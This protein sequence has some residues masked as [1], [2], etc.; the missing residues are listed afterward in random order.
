[1]QL[2]TPQ[3][4]RFARRVTGGGATIACSLSVAWWLTVEM[5][6]A[7][8]VAVATT[9]S[10]GQECFVYFLSPA[11]NLPSNRT[12]Q[13]Q[14]KTRCKSSPCKQENAPKKPHSNWQCK[15]NALPR[16]KVVQ[17]QA[18]QTRQDGQEGGIQK[19]A[20]RRSGQPSVID[21]GHVP[22]WPVHTLPPAPTGQPP[23]S[24]PV[25]TPTLPHSHATQ[26][27]ARRKPGTGRPNHA[28]P[29]PEKTPPTA[30]L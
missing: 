14:A 5:A 24:L 3:P 21:I 28:A 19:G 25:H 13:H 16:S 30:P 27:P 1:M 4:A 15:N 17:M 12:N 18:R 20:R 2:A 29:N 6:V 11:S 7:V 26:R 10:E 23:S 8:A 9:G 22:Q